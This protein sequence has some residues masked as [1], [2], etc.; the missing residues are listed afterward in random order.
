[1]PTRNTRRSGLRRSST[2]A[3]IHSD[4]GVV[5]VIG[6][7]GNMVQNFQLTGKYLGIFCISTNGSSDCLVNDWV[8]YSCH[9]DVIKLRRV[10]TRESFG[11]VTTNAEI[12]GFSL[13]SNGRMVILGCHNGQVHILEAVE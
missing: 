3:S 7:D 1:M 6:K 12:T 4:E 11:T 13:A 2:N 5:H 10:G 9:G 8:M